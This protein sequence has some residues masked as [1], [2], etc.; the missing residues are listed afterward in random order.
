MAQR[1]AHFDRSK[2]KL[3]G[4]KRE[5]YCKEEGKYK[6]FT[7]LRLTLPTKELDKLGWEIGDNLV[8]RAEKDRLWIEKE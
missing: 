5:Y 6:W 2:R 8:V 1:G 3:L 4:Y 7:V